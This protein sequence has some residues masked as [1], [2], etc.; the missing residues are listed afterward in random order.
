M[1]TFPLAQPVMKSKNRFYSYLFICKSNF[2]TFSNSYLCNNTIMRPKE[3]FTYH[4]IHYIRVH[5]GRLCKC[6]Y[7]YSFH[8]SP[9][10]TY[11]IYQS[12]FYIH[13]SC[14][15]IAYNNNHSMYIFINTFGIYPWYSGSTKVGMTNLV[16]QFLLLHNICLEIFAQKYHYSRSLITGM[17]TSKNFKKSFSIVKSW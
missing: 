1:L 7:G 10:I 8:I 16:L 17:I 15:H 5:L 13:S 9:R 12:R 11:S 14:L 2:H 6:K 3:W 4:F